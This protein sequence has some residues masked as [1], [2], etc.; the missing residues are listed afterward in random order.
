MRNLVVRI[1]GKH[2]A[3]WTAAIAAHILLLVALA[4][5]AVY[6]FR[7]NTGREFPVIVTQREFAE[8]EYD[9]TLK[10][11]MFKTPRI[12]CERMHGPY[13]MQWGKGSLSM[14]SPAILLEE[15]VEITKDIPTGTSI[16]CLSNKNI[17]T[18]S[19]VDAYGIGGAAA[20]A[21]GQR[22][23]KGTLSIKPLGNVVPRGNQKMGPVCGGSVPPNG[24]AHDAMFFKH[25]GCNPEIQTDDNRFST[26][27]VDVDTASY[28][29][30]RRYINGGN[31][32]PEEA[33]R[34]EEF[35]N[36]FDYGYAAPKEKT[37]GIYLDAAQTPFAKN[38]RILLRIGL[39]AREVKEADRKDAVLT[40][41]I[42]TSGSM[43]GGNR[44]ES[45]KAG[46][47]M[48]VSRLRPTE[49]VAIVEYKTN[50]RLVLGHTLV[51]E[52]EKI[53]T[54]IDQLHP[55]G[56]TNAYAG[57]K[58]GYQIAAQNLDTEC[59]NKVIL[60]SDGVANEAHT[61]AETILREVAEYR[62]KG[63]TLFCVGVG[64]GN[65]NDVLL[66]KLGDKGDGHYAYVDGIDEAKRIFIEN[67]T[68][69]L[70]TVAKDAKVQVEFN[71]KTVVSYRLVGYE[72]RRLKKEDFK[73]DKVDSGE[74]G[75]GHSVTALYVV[76]VRPEK[77]GKL[78]TVRLRW[79]DTA[80][81]EVE[82]TEKAIGTSKIVKDFDNATASFKLAAVVAQFAEIMRK[83]FWADEATLKGVV[84]ISGSLALELEEQKAA[85]FALLARAAARMKRNI[86]TAQKPAEK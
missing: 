18:T 17:E 62:R 63:I 54:S 34:V 39:K 53:L 20:G 57:L 74:V 36:F 77:E 35:V 49:K 50:A 48:L 2:G 83:S 68:G 25:Y 12:E 16:D 52:K 72:N 51:S 42:D 84:E 15:E 24:E 9:E 82:E 23:G 59:I 29:L 66:E 86:Q 3:A 76:K 1:V 67:V 31:L 40:L 55:G 65:Y 4:F 60:C 22:W 46:L 45:V 56:S 32:P 27:G 43:S 85:N 5:T 21:Y 13:G 78:A 7:G 81:K 10:R 75:A 26:F 11:A 41:V 33:V 80:T 28:T 61:D 47:R 38:N 70:Q 44:I 8:Q 58:L 37:F 30:C 73:N 19:C 64:M 71:V 79:K 6:V 69:T 14:E